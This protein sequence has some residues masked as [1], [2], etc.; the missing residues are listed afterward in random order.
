MMENTHRAQDVSP[1]CRTDSGD[2]TR[3]ENEVRLL[4]GEES[5]SVSPSTRSSTAFSQ[6]LGSSRDA[7][8][9]CPFPMLLSHTLL[10]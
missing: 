4:T 10:L 3:L 6:G 5:G 9:W 1:C 8:S 2:L 7:L